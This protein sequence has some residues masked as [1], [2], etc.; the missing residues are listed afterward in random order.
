[1]FELHD[2]DREINENGRKRLC[3]V[4]QIFGEY[5]KEL[6][7]EA[8]ANGAIEADEKMMR[9]D[10]SE[11]IEEEIEEEKALKDLSNQENDLD[12]LETTENN[13]NPLDLTRKS[14]RR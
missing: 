7:P 13:R 8:S 11:Q 3:Q 9:D 5:H 2:G 12:K 1:M 6:A 14:K 4:Q 10:N